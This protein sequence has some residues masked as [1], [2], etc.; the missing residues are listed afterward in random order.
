MTASFRRLGLLL[1]KI[2]CRPW[3]GAAAD[4]IKVFWFSRYW[5]TVAPF[6]IDKVAPWTVA[7]TEFGP[8]PAA[9]A[10]MVAVPVPTGWN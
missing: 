2:T 4:R 1:V 3:D 9:L 7:C 5:P 10:I 8:Y 6:A